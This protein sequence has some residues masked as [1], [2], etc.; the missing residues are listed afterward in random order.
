MGRTGGE[1]GGQGLGGQGL[2]GG[3]GDAGCR[4]RAS[5]LRVSKRNQTRCRILLPDI[6]SL[7]P[8]LPPS[9]PFPCPHLRN[10]AISLLER[11][12]A[13]QRGAVRLA[14]ATPGGH[15]D[16]AASAATTN[17]PQRFG[18]AHATA[19]TVPL[20]YPQLGGC[21]Y[22]SCCGCCSSCSSFRDA[23][24]RVTAITLLAAASRRQ[25]GS[26][27]CRRPCRYCRDQDDG[28]WRDRRGRLCYRHNGCR[29]RCCCRCCWR[30]RRCCQHSRRSQCLRCRLFLLGPLLL[31]DGAEVD[32][33]GGQLLVA[34]HVGDGAPRH[35]ND[36][37][38]SGEV[39]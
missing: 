38:S 1:E 27:G 19:S 16:H 8:S 35:H 2:G 15:L 10:L 37:I 20:R 14:Q 23:A 28:R 11:Q 7:P 30:G 4:G 17:V 32:P 3:A 21:R 9:S 6:A 36:H 5:A 18:P 26:S 34:S 22:C 33:A 39:L 29:C 12:R 24:R 25:R 31:D 13:Q